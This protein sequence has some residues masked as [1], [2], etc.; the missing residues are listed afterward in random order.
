MK[1]LSI[2]Q[3]IIEEIP[4]GGSM[5]LRE[6]AAAVG[7]TTKIAQVI[8][9]GML[10]KELVIR[11]KNICNRYQ[12]AH[13]TKCARRTGKQAVLD[14]FGNGGQD[15]V[16]LEIENAVYAISVAWTEGA[17]FAGLLNSSGHQT[18]QEIAAF[19]K[20]LVGARWKT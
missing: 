3:K 16:L 8:L 18:A 6:I 20:K 17:E 11:E 13:G 2:A 19:A 10:R 9:A 1:G 12:Y 4:Y 15:A 14:V 5:Q 7:T